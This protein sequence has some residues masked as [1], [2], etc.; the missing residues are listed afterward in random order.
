MMVSDPAGAPGDRKRLSDNPVIRAVSVVATLC[1]YAALGYAIFVTNYEFHV[2]DEGLAD[3]LRDSPGP[4]QLYSG[5]SDLELPK[6]VLQ[7]KLDAWDAFVNARAIFS[8]VMSLLT[9]LLLLTVAGCIL[10]VTGV[11]TLNL[12]SVLGG[13]ILLIIIWI[14]SVFLCVIYPLVLLI[15]WGTLILG[16]VMDGT[17][18]TGYAWGL[19]VMGPLAFVL[20]V[21]LKLLTI[22]L[23]F[24]LAEQ[25]PAGVLEMID[26]SA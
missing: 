6:V 25:G 1:S 8:M 11:V 15:I 3:R 21:G 13:T 4:H 19:L 22:A 20:S 16:P 12:E 24:V 17:C 26:R 10:I 14:G 18:T 23:C 7:S 5:T 9:A 2:T